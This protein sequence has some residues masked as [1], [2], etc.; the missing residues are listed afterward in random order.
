MELSEHFTFL[1]PGYQFMPSY[2][3]KRWD[4]KK[5][6]FNL[7]TRTL[8]AGLRYQFEQFCK[9]RNYTYE[10]ENDEFYEEYSLAEAEAFIK[11]LNLPPEIEIRDYQVSS[12]CRTI[13]QKGG[14]LVS[15]TGSGKTLLIYFIVRYME[16]I[17]EKGLFIVPRIQLTS[18]L[19]SDFKE[20]SSL[21]GWDVDANVQQI[22]YGQTKEITKFLTVSTW[23]SLITQEPE[24]FHKFDFVLGDEA[25]EFEAKSFDS[26]M[27][28]T[29][30]CSFR[31]GQTGSM[32]EAG[33][34]IHIWTLEGLFG[35][36]F[37]E[38]TTKEL[39]DKKYLADLKIKV[40]LLKHGESF[41][42]SA[43]GL[44][45]QE[46][47]GLLFGSLP[48]NQ[49]ITNLAI[50]LKGNT[51]ILFQYIEKHGDILEKMIRE[52]LA[53]DGVTRDVYYVHGA[54]DVEIREEIRKVVETKVDAIIIASVG[55][56]ATG[57]NIKS[58][59]NL[60]LASPSKARIK[61]LQSIGRILR[62]FKNKDTAIVFDIAD[63]LRLNTNK[64]ENYTL[65]HLV[66][67][68]KIYD[69]EKHEYKIYKIKLKDTK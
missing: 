64:K 43:K 25:H 44:K 12:F 2:K 42:R 33:A 69:D 47:I 53:K 26:I 32:K 36:S 62:L 54:T 30:N 58:L 55:T 49:F 1:V 7:R 22:F 15:P 27:S 24:W 38:T 29:K 68:L 6:L 39:M 20:Y 16:S 19:V 48:R 8:Y 3:H 61:I 52:A 40:L 37:Q 63:D 34:K 66:E 10:Y 23:Q 57:I 51:L 35:K 60:I 9:D 21:N 46:E 45:Y 28:N 50:S 17:K 56:F 4:G 65:K 31:Y 18:Q 67:R 14:L 5:R 11:S 13:R 59:K 41:C